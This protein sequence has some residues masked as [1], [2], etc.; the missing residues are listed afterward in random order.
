[1]LVDC[2][3]AN[4]DQSFNR[5]FIRPCIVSFGIDRVKKI[6]EEKGEQD[7]SKLEGIERLKYW[8]H[9]KENWI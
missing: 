6:I 9:P 8:L 7:S 1:P 4:Q 2:A 3:I 5:I